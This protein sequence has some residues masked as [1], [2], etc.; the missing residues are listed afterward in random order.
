LA[1]LTRDAAGPLASRSLGII[2]HGN[3]GSRVALRAEAFGLRVL[4]C[5]PPL[6]ERDPDFVSVPFEETLAADFVTLHVPLTRVGDGAHPTYHMI[7]A[8]ALARM[9]EG[10][11]LLNTSRG[12]AVDSEALIDVLA[13]GRIAG[14]VLDVYEGEPEPVEELLRLPV[15]TTPHIAGYAVEAKRRGAIVVYEAMCR[16]F[17]VQPRDTGDLL[18]GGLE[19]RVGVPVDFP[20]GG[21]TE[22]DADAAF[23][24]LLAAIYDIGATSR[25]LKGTIG[26]EGRRRLFDAMRRDY[27]KA[28]GR[29]EL[30][31]YRV[32]FGDSV[33]PD[34]RAEV[35]RRGAGF[36]MKVDASG[37]HFVLHAR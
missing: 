31:A 13:D 3:C 33:G 37:A 16:A 21:R 9:H 35:A 22:V 14:A 28:C 30:A 6:A 8:T 20:V 19:P 23:R 11:Y 4:R 36:G 7:D 12:A 26:R 10:A 32:G 17:G 29:H 15:L 24:A 2:G 1:W 25:E 27:E 18:R 34:L 5:D